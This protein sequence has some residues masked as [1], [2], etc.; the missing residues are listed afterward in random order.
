MMPNGFDLLYEDGPCFAVAKPGGLLTQAPSTIDSLESRVRGFLHEREQPSGKIYLGMPHRLD[1]PA[2][3]VIVMARNVRA[4]R[5]ICE[6]FQRREVD[7]CYWAIVEGVVSPEQ[8]TWEDYVRKVPD[9][10]AAEVVTP[11]SAGA[12]I[13]ILHYEVLRTI[14]GHSLLEI[15]LETGRTHQIRLQAASRGHAIWGDS[16]YG[17]RELFGPQVE[18]PRDKW[19]AL[20]ATRISLDHPK[21]RE[22]VTVNAPLPSVWQQTGFVS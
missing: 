4:T 10:A 21:S 5:R 19:I 14:E 15:R 20:H 6:Q 8:G 12:K 13:A 1:R 9:V 18:E 17:S 11:D 7:K 22:R 16:Q 2:T 3:G